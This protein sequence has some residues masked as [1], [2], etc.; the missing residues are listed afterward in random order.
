MQE[1]NY[2]KEFKEVIKITAFLHDYG[3]IAILDAILKK[4][5]KLSSKEYE[6]IKTHAQKTKEILQ[7]IH[8][9]DHFKEIPEI[10]GS[11][12]E[13]IDGSG[14]P[15]GLKGDQIHVGA[16]IIAV[17]DIFEA[18]TSKRH[19]RDP[20]PTE[21]AF[22]ILRKDAGIKYE[23]AFVEALIRY[24]KKRYVNIYGTVDKKNQ[25]V[26]FDWLMS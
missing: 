21:V 1:L 3:K 18:I 19:Y 4:D 25:V 13:K 6:L 24:Y 12:H 7:Q 2:S 11:H 14:Y 17:A 9:E 16:K 10:A 26:L 23:K 22:N 8:F 5:G 15:L 20:L